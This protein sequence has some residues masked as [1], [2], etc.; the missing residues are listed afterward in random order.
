MYLKESDMPGPTS[1]ARL[2]QIK[3]HLARDTMY[4]T[5]NDVREKHPH[6]TNQ[7]ARRQPRF[8]AAKQAYDHTVDQLLVLLGPSVPC[9]M[10]DLDQWL[11][12]SDWYKSAYGCRPFGA[13]ITR[14]EIQQQFDGLAMAA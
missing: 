2:L 8:Q 1:E 12:Y 7:D 14:D 5:L 6:L 11:E 4:R 10:V 3:Q 9:F 13:R